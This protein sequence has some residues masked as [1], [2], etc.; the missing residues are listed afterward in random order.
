[1]RKK[2]LHKIVIITFLITLSPLH[3]VS[4][5]ARDV[6]TQVG[7]GWFGDKNLKRSGRFNDIIEVPGGKYVILGSDTTLSWF[8][9]TKIELTVPNPGIQSEKST[10]LGYN[11]IAFIMVIDT[12]MDNS[13]SIQKIFYLP[14]GTVENFR[15]IKHTKQPYD[16]SGN[17]Q[18]GDVFISGDRA[19]EVKAGF[20]IGK[21]NNNFVAG[22]PTGFAWIYNVYAPLDNE[23]G[24]AHPWDVGG[25]GKVVFATGRGFSGSEAFTKRLKMDGT[26][27]IVPNWKVHFDNMNTKVIGVTSSFSP[28][29][30]ATISHSA[31]SF[32]KDGSGSLQ[33]MNLTDYNRWTGDGKSGFKKGTYPMDIF[34]RGDIGGVWDISGQ[35]GYTGYKPGSNPSGA[36]RTICIDRRTNEMYFGFS[37]Q[38]TLPWGLPDF[39]PAVMKMDKDGLLMW[40]TRLYTEATTNNN[41]DNYN[42]VT[43]AQ[44]PN[45]KLSSPDQF[46]DGLLIDYINN[47]L[48][49]HARCH[50]ND[51]SNFWTSPGAFQPFTG[52]E[53]NM[54]IGWLG[55]FDL[56][57]NGASDYPP[58]NPLYT[59]GPT[60]RFGTYVAGYNWQAPKGVKY[61]TTTY[62][63]LRGW[64]S[65]NAGGINGLNN[66]TTTNIRPNSV[67]VNKFGE[68][69]VV[70]TGKRIVTTSNAF[71]QQ[72]SLYDNT[73]P[74]TDF[75]RVYKPDLTAVTYSSIVHSSF[76]FGTPS[77]NKPDV[78]LQNIIPLS[79]LRSGLVTVGYNTADV[80]NK[81][82]IN[83]RNIPL[84]YGIDWAN[85]PTPFIAKLVGDTAFKD[86]QVQSESQLPAIVKPN[87]NGCRGGSVTFDN[88][89]NTIAVF[90]GPRGNKPSDERLWKVYLGKDL[91][92]RNNAGKSN[93]IV[94]L[95]GSSALVKY[96]SVGG[97]SWFVDM[98]YGYDAPLGHD[99]HY[100]II[101]RPF[102]GRNYAFEKVVT[103]TNN[104][105]YILGISAND[106][107]IDTT[108]TAQ[109]TP[110]NRFWYPKTLSGSL[111]SLWVSS[112]REDG[113]EKHKKSSGFLLKYSKD[114]KYLWGKN[115][116]GYNNVGIDLAFKSGNIPANDS[117]FVTW[118]LHGGNGANNK[119]IG[120]ACYKPDGN[121]NFPTSIKNPGSVNTSWQG[122]EENF[123]F[124]ENR[125]FVLRRQKNASV[126]LDGVVFT[127]GTHF[128]IELDNNGRYK[129][130]YTPL[131]LSN[132]ITSLDKNFA[133]T[134]QE[135]TY[136]GLKLLPRGGGGF[137]LT[138]F[139]LAGIDQGGA[140]TITAPNGVGNIVSAITKK[141]LTHKS[142]PV[143]FV[144]LLKENAVTK[145]FEMDKVVTFDEQSNVGLPDCSMAAGVVN[146]ELYLAFSVVGDGTTI[147]QGSRFLVN[148]DGTHSGTLYPSGTNTTMLHVFKVA[149]NGTTT[150][151]TS[152]KYY[153][154]KPSLR[155]ISFDKSNNPNILFVNESVG[156][157]KYNEVFLN[158]KNFSGGF[159]NHEF[160]GFSLLRYNV[161][162][163][164]F[165][166]LKTFRWDPYAEWMPV[167]ASDPI[168]FCDHAS[169]ADLDGRVTKS[170]V[171]PATKVH[172][173][174]QPT[175]H[176]SE[177]LTNMSMDLFKPHDMP[178][179]M[180]VQDTT[181]YCSQWY[182]GDSIMSRR[183]PLRIRRYK[184]PQLIAG[185]MPPACQALDRNGQIVLYG[186]K[187]DVGVMVWSK[188]PD[189][190][191][192]YLIGD[193][194]RFYQT[195]SP[196]T[197]Y[198]AADNGGCRSN[199]QQYSITTVPDVRVTSDS[200]CNNVPNSL[201]AW[202]VNNINSTE[203]IGGAVET[204]VAATMRWYDAPTG[205]NMLIPTPANGNVTTLN[206]SK[207]TY[208]TT[209]P[210]GT[211]D[212]LWVEAYVAG[213][214]CFTP[215]RTPVYAYNAITP[216]DPVV[217]P[218]VTLC[219]NV[220]TTLTASCATAG[221][222]IKWYSEST[223]TSLIYTGA[224]LETGVI[225]A[226][227]SK[228]YY[229]RAENGKCISGVKKVSV[230]AVTSPVILVSNTL[231]VTEPATVDATAAVSSTLGVTSVLTYWDD[232]LCTAPYINPNAVTV[233]DTV[234]V[235]GG[236][237]ICDDV[238]PI[239]VTVFSA[240]KL[241][242]TNPAAVC[243]SGTVNITAP[244]VTTG[245][246]ADLTLTYW[247][248]AAATSQISILEAEAITMTGTYYIKGVSSTSGLSNIKPV[249]VT[250]NPAPSGLS[251]GSSHLV[252]IKGSAITTAFP[253]VAGGEV[254]SYGISPSLPV[255]VNFNTISGVISGTPI[256]LLAQTIFTITA[257]NNCGSTSG[258][259][260]LAVYDVAPS[261]LS[262]L[263][264]PVVATKGI[265]AVNASPTISGGEVV[266]YSI[267]PAL[268]A[269]MNFNTTTGVISGTPTVLLAQT[270][271]TITA[272]NTGGST[273]GTF[274]L[275]VNDVAP[276][277]LSYPS[278]PV[279]STKGVTVVNASPTISGDAVVSYSISPVLPTGMNFNTTTGDISGTPTVLLAQTTFTI[280]ASNTGGSTTGIFTLTV[281]DP[282]P[283]AIIYNPASFVATKG[284]TAISTSPV[285]ATG[286]S[287][288]SIS[289][290][291][292]TGVS[293]NTNTG[294]I[295]GT[296]TELLAQTIFTITASNTGGST[297][298][299]FTLTVNDVA[300]SGL[301]YSTGTVIA[302]KGIT[303]INSTPSATGGA[304]VS[305][306]ISPALPTG[307]NFNTTTG[308]ISG[309]PTVLLAQTT[310]T[311]TATNTGGSTSGTFTLTVNDPAPGTL[312]YNPAN[313]VATK[314][315]T[316]I[317]SAPTVATGL[318]GFS[319]SPTLPTGVGLNINTGVISGTPTVILA[320]TNFTISANKVSGGKATGIFRLTVNDAAPTNLQYIPDSIICLQ[321][322]TKVNLKAIVAGENI[323]YSA[324]PNLPTGLILNTT[325]GTISGKCQTTFAKTKFTVKATNTGG[326][327]TKEILIAS[328]QFA[329]FTYKQSPLIA[330]KKQV[331]SD[332]PVSTYGKRNFSITPDLP[333][334]LTINSSTGEISG[335]AN[336]LVDNKIF[337]IK[338]NGDFDT[339]SCDLRITIKLPEIKAE[340][341]QTLC[342]PAT[343]SDIVIE[344]PEG[345]QSKWWSKSIG[346]DLLSD[347]TKLWDGATYFV[348]TF[349]SETN[350]SSTSR[351]AIKVL[352][353]P[354][355]DNTIQTEND[356]I[357][358]D[359]SLKSFRAWTQ[360]V[361]GGKYTWRFVD[362]TELDGYDID[363]PIE[364]KVDSNMVKIILEVQ[365]KYGCMHEI[366]RYIPL[367]PDEIPNTFTPN[368][369]GI[370]DLFMKGFDI[371]IYNRNGIKIFE[372]VKGWDGEY[373]GKVVS[374][375]TYF[376]NVLIHKGKQTIKR[377]GFVTV[378]RQL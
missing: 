134:F 249:I 340:Q 3:N 244:S 91:F 283:G 358:Y 25:D 11:K 290:A 319:I 254:V 246:D 349:D 24:E 265:T 99:H 158:E 336:E 104:D 357:K 110:L 122:D 95:H 176:Y 200:S 288:F 127:G 352:N 239:K 215:V 256:E 178:L 148:D 120:V 269:G 268:P 337:T 223:C 46:L 202:A 316:L 193:T 252:A 74:W 140:A 54:H 67:K 287:G 344:I 220:N 117:I 243:E 168:K 203:T 76:I 376:Y 242:I 150:S 374:N 115:F 267:S 52:T 245:S 92:G 133:I 47:Q 304:V 347:T 142:T 65:H 6:V 93:N 206:T 96:N 229:A 369:D 237:G 9:G 161:A 172:Y 342:F 2:I 94:G 224:N 194:V 196:T 81:F 286:L 213:T 26:L 354:E 109:N 183:I 250:I 332:E 17:L 298:G 294:V 143:P 321:N 159:T 15:F 28:A 175:E 348:E 70:G 261:G 40:W 274:T 362:D 364:N 63:L 106:N 293:L 80:N 62:P 7:A 345:Y 31:C 41:A 85:G 238:R 370:N 5:V 308:I 57:N 44:T 216:D 12:T 111:D 107:E 373:K 77:Y 314:G 101:D 247:N 153:G 90:Q 359:S 217:T 100:P 55:K 214:G 32:R 356:E 119:T 75:V 187:A 361:D 346:G 16:G 255:G 177:E 27:D 103:D 284:V 37:F 266:T 59:Q 118:S 13:S 292:P 42:W 35:G 299:T 201:K 113:H 84:T 311:I 160:H 277:G 149:S 135:R 69:F 368:N 129:S 257:T 139:A 78:S 192:P 272:S 141:N 169:L 185:N 170:T 126:T 22:D 174:L 275:T 182:P 317:N 209:P 363:I 260:T 21:L 372:G 50:G 365:N 189:L 309:T 218:N 281:N 132:I 233:S 222:V 251:Y 310:F 184:T 221:A 331:V 49:V 97:L 60:F 285:N 29:V 199:I 1:M 378:S 38:S 325:K 131:T 191:Q 82:T 58:A 197:Y 327:V 289:P 227:N 303:V 248:N 186:A 367:V 263:S 136:R 30:L 98:E 236:N 296:P 162:E 322:Y 61:N 351:L 377:T 225:N 51:A 48:I 341:T 198:F 371:E 112:M 173:Y 228:D 43:K 87:P 350:L 45:R 282:A 8:V 20:F 188:N 154:V 73:A 324:L 138:G 297:S 295:S 276:S 280:T 278:S 334:A 181:Y 204:K 34:Y 300:P 329:G 211:R 114:G 89:F 241:I 270:E 235:K 318:S 68:I 279:V 123:C 313:V 171:Q 315:V 146:G 121:V 145:K 306:S 71:L 320:Q 353:S 232:A 240:P 253:T 302:T 64:V 360:L 152:N 144:A 305:Y 108:I 23:L 291:L 79:N 180:D 130:N 137:Y 155:E 167:G 124:I 333:S 39:E 258:T 86:V 36:I 207:S 205:G 102:S 88:E 157:T 165:D 230:N 164:K 301:T 156:E 83:F 262:Y 323:T 179:G 190:S 4:A 312:I 116:D 219:G 259:F 105:I 355:I 195:S 343:I 151:I 338:G 264:S 234:Y 271:F 208:N 147:G 125:K 375:G 339:I 33:S 335:T 231:P 56:Y 328:N 163:S 19:S 226:G 14:A 307:M 128:I 66:L 273:S 72:D 366:I 210:L 18:I 326:F 212:T 53:G 10:L 166:K 330:D